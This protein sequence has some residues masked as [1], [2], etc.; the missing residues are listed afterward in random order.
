MVLTCEPAAVAPLEGC[1]PEA[2]DNVYEP[3]ACHPRARR[4][5]AEITSPLYVSEYPAGFVNRKRR[6]A[7]EFTSE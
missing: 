5:S 3:N 4:F 6:S 2:L 1:S 7:V